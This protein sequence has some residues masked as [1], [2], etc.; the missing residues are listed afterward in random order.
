MTMRFSITDAP[1][2][3]SYPVSSTTWAI[4]YVNQPTGKAQAITDFLRWV[5][6][7]GQQFSEPLQ[8]APL[9]AAL[10]E[11]AEHQIGEVAVNR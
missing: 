2:K 3:D 9:P 5:I 1:G 11:R 8:Y 6:H 10:V 7:E 4:V